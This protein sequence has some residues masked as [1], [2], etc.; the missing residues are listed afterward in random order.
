MESVVIRDYD[1]Q[2]PRQF[3]EI[4]ARVRA[5]FAGGPLLA[6]EHVGSTAVPGLAAKPIID[7]D[8]VIPSEADLPDAGSRLAALGYVYEGDN[9]IPGRTAFLWPPGTQRHHLYVCASGNLELRRQLAFR[10]YLRVNPGAARRYESLKRD[11]ARRFREDRRAYSDGKTEFVEA[12]LAKAGG[13][14][15]DEIALVEYDPRWPGLFAEEAAR[16]RAALGNNLLVAVE[17]FGSTAVPGLAAKPVI[18]LLVGVRSVAE[19]KKTAVAPLEAL[20]YAYWADNPVQ[21]RLFFVRGL[22]PNGSR[23]HHIH[24]VELGT[25][26]DPKNGAFLFW[27][28]LLFR[29]Y[30]RVNPD[31]ARRYEDL[32]RALAAR[33]PGDRE[34]YPEGKTEYVYGVMQKARAR[35]SE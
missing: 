29:D 10:D 24:M 19:A 9:G 15:M 26:P 8:M 22:P 20:G 31:E 28:R 5:A 27:D 35:P 33:H 4:A 3:A 30:L 32:K 17:H 34:A 21:D 23:T 18:D 7:L 13:Q 2:W 6:I 14:S 25:S 12:V 1:P 16:V 11:L